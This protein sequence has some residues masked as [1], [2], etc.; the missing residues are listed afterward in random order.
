MN[1]SPS[2]RRAWDKRF[3][4]ALDC[5]KSSDSDLELFTQITIMAD[6]LSRCSRMGAG[7]CSASSL[8]KTTIVRNEH[9]QFDKKKKALYQKYTGSKLVPPATAQESDAMSEDDARSREKAMLD[10]MPEEARP[11]WDWKSLILDGKRV[12]DRMATLLAERVRGEWTI[13]EEGQSIDGSSQ[14]A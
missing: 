4:R 5:S 1:H 10:I 6:A 9:D 11:E 2:D 14:W 8:A 3:N 7:D 12:R 13:D